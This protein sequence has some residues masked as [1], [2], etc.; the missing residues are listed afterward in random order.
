MKKMIQRSDKELVAEVNQLHR[1]LSTLMLDS[2]QK[3]IKA[4]EIL[5]EL[6][7]RVGHGG[8]RIWVERNL[9]FSIRTASRYM[10]CYTRR[11]ELSGV[12]TL[13]DAADKLADKERGMDA[14]GA[15]YHTIVRGLVAPLRTVRRRLAKLSYSGDSAET[16]EL[17]RE[18]VRQE[19]DEL[20]ILL[21]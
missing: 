11:D 3:A 8:W 15:D 2:V 21:D 13:R 9:S 14:I 4:G 17:I 7:L 18:K 12:K 10:S 16:L 19:L 6:K 20:R 1:E 5:I